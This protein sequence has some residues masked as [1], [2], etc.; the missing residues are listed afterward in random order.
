M[1]DPEPLPRS[2]RSETTGTWQVAG[3]SSPFSGV[4]WSGGDPP[5]VLTGSSVRRARTM[6]GVLAGPLPM[7]GPGDRIDSF[8]L[9]EAIGVGGMGAVFRAMTPGSTA[10]SR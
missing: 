6:G 4:A 8:E 9:H 1:L 5:T 10:R 3:P 2:E 7:P